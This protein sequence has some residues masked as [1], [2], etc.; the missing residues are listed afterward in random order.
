M[1][2][3]L[4]KVIIV[5]F[6]L[7]IC[8]FA[9][10]Q[11]TKAR[12]LFWPCWS[13]GCGDC[14]SDGNVGS[15]S[16][17]SASCGSG[18]QSGHDGCNTRYQGCCSVCYVRSSCSSSYGPGTITIDNSCG[19]LTYENCCTPNCTAANTCNGGNDGCGNM[20]CNNDCITQNKVCATNKICSVPTPYP[21]INIKG[22]LKNDY[23]RVANQCSDDFSYPPLIA[24]TPQLSISP[25]GAGVSYTC[26]PISNGQTSY[27][28]NVV[29]NNQANVRLSA[30]QTITLSNTGYPGG[31]YKTYW[32][33]ECTGNNCAQGADCQVR[34]QTITVDVSAP[35]PFFVKNM[36]FSPDEGWFKM[37]NT[38]FS[39]NNTGQRNNVIPQSVIAYDSDDTTAKQLIVGTAGI[40]SLQSNLDMV[41]TTNYSDTNWVASSYETKRNMTTTTAY[42][43]YLKQK[44]SE[45]ETISDVSS[46]GTST[47]KIFMYNSDLTIDPGTLAMIDKK[48]LTLIVNGN[49]DFNLGDSGSFVPTNSIVIIAKKI[50]FYNKNTPAVANTNWLGDLK[51]ARGVFIADNI[52][53]GSSINIGLKITGNI[54]SLSGPMANTRK[55]ADYRIPSVFIVF[56]P[57]IYIDTIGVFGSKTYNWTE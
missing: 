46:I 20:V 26:N 10:S 5:S 3:I 16:A 41:N 57:L 14:Q 47:K 12:F 55:Q 45:F 28:C 43:D 24:Y 6:I 35:N 31:L 53:V 52:D 18:T 48:S 9:S 34:N 40:T 30:T 44:S 33:G 49:V 25:G 1:K 32:I 36:Y 11:V 50:M 37:S 23:S 8:L 7:L 13:G 4:P 56:D 51:E 15:W 2:K 38:T 54:I 29:I 39:S 22:T 21:T 19:S 17:C 42:I 27:S